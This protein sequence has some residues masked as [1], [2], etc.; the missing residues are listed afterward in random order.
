MTEPRTYALG[1]H[2]DH[3]ERSRNFAAMVPAVKPK[4]VLWE[5]T[6]PV[7][8]QGAL[9]SCTGNALAQWLNTDYARGY[10]FDGMRAPLSEAA[11]VE[12]YSAATRADNVPGHY[13]P[14]DTGS[15]GLAVCRAAVR[16]KY[17]RAY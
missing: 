16:A 6:A 10:Q 14:V 11:A 13:P 12:L 3:D 4:T 5:H 7:L 17:L 2:V 9:G 8:D 15:S 1:R